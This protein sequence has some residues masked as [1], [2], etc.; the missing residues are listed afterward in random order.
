MTL[1]LV[2]P[3][4]ARD[5]VTRKVYFDLISGAGNLLIVVSN[6]IVDCGVKI[7]ETFQYNNLQFSV[8]IPPLLMPSEIALFL[9]HLDEYSEWND[10]DIPNDL[11]VCVV[12]GNQAT[13]DITGL[14]NSNYFR[15]FILEDV[16]PSIA[17]A[18]DDYE[19][20]TVIER[21]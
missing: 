5:T 13:K 6:R 17:L 12:S 10:C 9:Q 4:T 1:Y 16:R 8:S 14:I 11:I 7:S 2:S 19:P 3:L 21:Q 18:L 20:K 15:F